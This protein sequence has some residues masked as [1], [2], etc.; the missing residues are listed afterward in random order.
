MSLAIID[1]R[2]WQN[3]FD[4]RTG[5]K[6]L[7]DSPK[8]Q[9]VKKVLARHPFPGDMAELSNRW[10][11][12][13]AL[14]LVEQYD[15]RFAFLVYAQQYYAFRFEKQTETMRE[16]LID[17]AFNEV[18]R[19]TRETG[20]TPLVVGT[21]AMVPATEYID[22]SSLDGLA[23][24]SHWLT[25]Y[26]G[27]YDMS[28]ADLAVLRKHA[29]IERLVSREEFKALFN[30]I[31]VDDARLPELLAVAHPGYCFRSTL[32]RRPVMIS[33]QNY[34]VPIS[35]ALGEIS[36]LLDISPRIDQA[37]AG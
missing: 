22:L 3:V 2:E 11:T 27:L 24:T 18:E 10:V 28:T 5:R 26:A 16:R 31:S 17:S 35:T 8:I 20:F 30:E 6:R 33:A 29:G 12:D 7:D 15:S 37:F 4:L 34:F 25:Q 13:T 14:D 19:F 36:S 23:I 9:L 1:A 32:L 21:G